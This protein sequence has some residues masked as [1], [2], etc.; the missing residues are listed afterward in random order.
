MAQAQAIPAATKPKMKSVA[1]YR[2][3]NLSAVSHGK[4]SSCSGCMHASGEGQGLRPCWQASAVHCG[5]MLKDCAF[6]VCAI[7]DLELLGLG[8]A[9]AHVAHDGSEL[10]IGG[11]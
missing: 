4:G 6:G 11:V 10:G 3:Q 9:M 2:S 1:R 5:S 8:H 7:N